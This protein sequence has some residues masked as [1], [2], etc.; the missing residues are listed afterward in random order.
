M[1]FQEISTLTVI[2]ENVPKMLRVHHVSIHVRA[3]SVFEI[4]PSRSPDL[5]LV[6]MVTRK[7]G[8]V[9]RSNLQRRHTSTHFLRLSNH[10]QRH[11][12][13]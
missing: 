6:S 12:D 10:P 1:T 11:R 3:H 13:L 4:Q 5:N 7:N 9:F 2:I 8:S